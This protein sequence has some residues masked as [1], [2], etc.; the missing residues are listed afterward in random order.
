[1]KILIVPIGIIRITLLT[2]TFICLT[3]C[4]CLQ[5][6][7]GCVIDKE[8]GKPIMGINVCNEYSNTNCFVTDSMGR[9]DLKA[10]SGGLLGCP[11]MKINIQAE[12]YVTKKL[13]IRNCDFKTIKLK[14]KK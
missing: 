5:R 7:S 14:R 13:K 1:M 11:S 10:M 3:A 4:D 2:I 6:V 12:G 9:F 8:T